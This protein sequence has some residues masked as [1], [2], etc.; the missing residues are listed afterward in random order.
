VVHALEFTLG[1]ALRVR[2][3]FLHPDEAPQVAGC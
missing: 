2:G 1:I 3:E